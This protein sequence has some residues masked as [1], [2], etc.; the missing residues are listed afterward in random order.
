MARSYAAMWALFASFVCGGLG[1]S[2]VPVKP[3]SKEG[4]TCAPADTVRA[5]IL[6]DRPEMVLAVMQSAHASASEQTCLM[7]EIFTSDGELLERRIKAEA[8]GEFGSQHSVRVTSLLEA[9]I[10]LEELGITPVWMKPGFRKGAAGDPRRTPWSLREPAS[11]SDPK[12]AHPLNLLRFYLPQLPHMQHGRILLF[13][14]DVCISDDLRNLYHDVSTGDGFIDATEPVIVASCQMQQW[15]QSLGGFRVR[16]GEFTYADM[17]F[18]GTTGGN[19]G[20]EVC[21]PEADMDDEE[22]ANGDCDKSEQKRPACAPGS[23]EPKLTQ[24]HS[25]ISGL[26]T[27]RNET[28]WNFGVTLVHLDRWRASGMDRRFERWF[29]ANEHF[30]FFAPTSISFGLGLAY[31]ALAGHVKCWPQ[32]TVL[33]GLGYLT[34]QDFE[35]SGM[36]S[37]DIA[38]RVPRH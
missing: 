18:L 27:F 17:P 35:A 29:A 34:W 21:H 10:A 37:I 7:W 33:D 2:S 20:Y 22:R 16:T 15:D 8:L 11:D 38:V 32:G 12:H 31:L 14:D 13:D 23:L 24:L 6:S 5:G 28:A 25:E 3:P 26:S 9:E 19:G 36:G 30:A 1:H 4:R